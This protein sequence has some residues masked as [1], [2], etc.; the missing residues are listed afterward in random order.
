MKIELTSEQLSK[1]ENI[2]SLVFVTLWGEGWEN[3]WQ[4]LLDDNGNPFTDMDKA[5]VFV[6]SHDV[7]SEWGT[8]LSTFEQAAVGNA[9]WDNL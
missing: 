5:K 7:L 9:V 4:V 2:T 3:T 8:G 6:R 1:L